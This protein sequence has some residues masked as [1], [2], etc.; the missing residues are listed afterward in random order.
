MDCGRDPN[1]HV[2]SRGRKGRGGEQSAR[3]WPRKHPGEGYKMVKKQGARLKMRERS[4]T[5]CRQEKDGEVRDR[6][7][8]APEA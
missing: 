4:E 7:G 3:W 6:G 8:R 2:G 1:K 5:T